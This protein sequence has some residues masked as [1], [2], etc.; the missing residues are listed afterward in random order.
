M[1][2]YNNPDQQ[3]PKYVFII[4]EMGLLI[5]NE[6][7][8]LPTVDEVAYYKSINAVEI[9]MYEDSYDYIVAFLKDDSTE[10]DNF[11]FILF[12]EV[13]AI[14]S[15][16][17]SLA[18]RA[19]AIIKWKLSTIFCATCSTYL[20]DCVD[21]TALECT[22]CNKR[23][24]PSISPAIIV[25]IYKDDL[26][27]LAHHANRSHDFYTCLAGYVEPGETL[28][29]CV[30]REVK[31]EVGLNV[32]DIE[33]IK[34]QPWPFPN[35]LMLGFRC[36]WVSGEIVVDKTEIEDAAWYS[37]DNLPKIPPKGTI[38]NYLITHDRSR[39]FEL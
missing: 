10:I 2:L 8:E 36:N 35:Q 39:D 27:L 11:T 1:A 28:E 25:Q 17:A 38:A 37:K 31:E 5:H 20:I 6:T 13:F 15:N 22:A 21:E 12:R 24:Y 16:Y 26:L 3:N 9:V 19:R 18:A 14:E 34:N 29:E 7:Q 4:K 23:Y 32:T 33:Y 30:R